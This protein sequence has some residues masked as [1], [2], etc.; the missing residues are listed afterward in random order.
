MQTSSLGTESL[1]LPASLHI[2]SFHLGNTVWLGT[3]DFEGYLRGMSTQAGFA[4]SS[5]ESLC[6]SPFQSKEIDTNC[7]FPSFFHIPY[8]LKGAHESTSHGQELQ[9]PLTAHHPG[10]LKAYTY[11]QRPGTAPRL[12]IPGSLREKGERIQS[13]INLICAGGFDT[14]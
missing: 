12:D 10:P 11:W 7:F 3:R 9:G 6:S 14:A 5:R 2:S 8:R 4:P 1:A 13:A